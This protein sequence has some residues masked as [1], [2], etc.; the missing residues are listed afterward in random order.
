MTQAQVLRALMDRRVFNMFANSIPA[1]SFDEPFVEVFQVIRD[2][3]DSYDSER[4]TKDDLA[5]LAT[6]S[7]AVDSVLRAK[8]PKSPDLVVENVRR[9][10][11]NATMMGV[12]QDFADSFQNGKVDVDV[13]QGKMT[14]IQK[15]FAVIADGIDVERTPFN[16]IFEQEHHERIFPMP[17]E[18]L[19]DRLDGGPTAGE[20]L[21]VLAPPDGGKTQFLI[22][23][24][25]NG[26][27][28]GKQIL[29]FTLE[30]TPTQ[31]IQRYYCSCFGRGIRTVMEHQDAIVKYQRWLR[32]IAGGGIRLYD[33][34]DREMRISDMQRA[35]EQIVESGKRVDTV[36]IDYGDLVR[37]AR[38]YTSQHA[39]Q[40]EVWRE[41]CRMAKH[42]SIPVIIA[43]Q[44]NRQGAGAGSSADLTHVAQSWAKATDS[45]IC[46]LVD[47]SPADKQR[48][49]A[50]LRILKTKKS[51]GYAS[52][53]CIFDTKRCIVK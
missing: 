49:T 31:W 41:A 20:L 11:V 33:G 50:A 46:I 15:R 4:L 47:R 10:A 48:G 26:S 45:Q 28:Q 22:N 32:K 24:A 43:S 7:S 34:S 12:F 52:V 27:E 38:R 21:T 1:D 53:Q 36:I 37:S 23:A 6:S 44:L 25:R 29:Y 17:V 2:Y 39:E 5:G 3:F 35:A 51:G 13:I 8:I 14:E 40:Q 30:T 9:F 42:L 19:N 16:D 18:E